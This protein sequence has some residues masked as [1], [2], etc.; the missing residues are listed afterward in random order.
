MKNILTAEE[1]EKLASL[2]AEYPN[3]EVTA[4][5]CPINKAGDA[6]ITAYFREP[7]IEEIDAYMRLEAHN[8]LLS[9]RQ[10]LATVLVGVT[11]AE[12]KHLIENKYFVMGAIP[13]VDDS[14]SFFQAIVKKKETA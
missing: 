3:G 2:Q 4:A 12:K 14:I 9:K 7:T 13:I 11:D 5:T 10:L 8:P 6:Y 1:L